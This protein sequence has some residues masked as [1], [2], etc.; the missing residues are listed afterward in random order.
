MEWLVVRAPEKMLA[1]GL[2]RSSRVDC[3]SQTFLHTNT[4]SAELDRA[5]SEVN[6][7]IRG[8]PRTEAY[9]SGRSKVS[10]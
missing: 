6:A 3:I 1:T 5:T 10:G 9:G 7:C 2:A 4:H 8:S